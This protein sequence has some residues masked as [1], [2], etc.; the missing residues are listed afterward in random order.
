MMPENATR[1]RSCPDCDDF[2]AVAITTGQL[3]ADGTRE[4][5]NVSCR[6]CHGTG[7]VPVRSRAA[8]REV[9]A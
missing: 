2:P 5:V 1:T 9:A 7:T 4:T 8:A 6:T 3:L